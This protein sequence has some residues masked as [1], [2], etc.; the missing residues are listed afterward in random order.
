MEKINIRKI[1]NQKENMKENKNEANL[2][3][4]EEY[5]KERNMRK[6]LKKKGNIKKNK[7][8]QNLEPKTEYEKTRMKKIVNQK[9]KIAKRCIKKTKK[10]FNNVE[11]FCRQIR[12]GPIQ[13][14]QCVISTFINTIS[15]YLNMKNI[16]FLMQNCI[17]WSVHLM[18]K[19]IY[20]I[21]V[22]NNFLKMKCHC[23]TVFNEIGLDPTCDQLKDLK[24]IEKI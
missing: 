5:E 18:K 1:L 21:H 7:Y 11:K 2:E 17:V 15:D 20:A 22:R 14:A 16:I 24:R 4:N 6:I 19:F 3:P 10:S 23:Q 9:K 12:Q 13:F 8:E